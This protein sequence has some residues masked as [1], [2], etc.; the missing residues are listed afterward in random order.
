MSTQVPVAVEKNDPPRTS[1]MRGGSDT[2]NDGTLSS[3]NPTIAIGSSTSGVLPSWYSTEAFENMM[4]KYERIYSRFP[5]RLQARNA[6]LER[7]LEEYEEIHESAEDDM[8][9]YRE[10]LKLLEAEIRELRGE[11]RALTEQNRRLRRKLERKEVIEAEGVQRVERIE[12]PASTSKGK[13]K[14]VAKATEKED[15]E[16]VLE[17]R[18]FY[19][20]PSTSTIVLPGLPARILRF[21]RRVDL[22]GIHDYLDHQYK[23]KNEC[24]EA[25]TIVRK[26]MDANV[27]LGIQ[28]P[29]NLRDQAV[30]ISLPE[31]HDDVEVHTGAKIAA[32][33]TV[34][35]SDGYIEIVPWKY[36]EKKMPLRQKTTTPK[37]D[38]NPHDQAQQTIDIPIPDLAS[39]LPPNI[40]TTLF[41]PSSPP[42]SICSCALC[43][44]EYD[45]N[46]LVRTHMKP[47]VSVR[48]GADDDDYDDYYDDDEY[49]DDGYYDEEG[50]YDSGDSD[51][52]E[53]V[54]HED[55]AQDP[56]DDGW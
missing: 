14:E 38:D 50:D 46:V 19:F 29:D 51:Y 17:K 35:D 33:R 48:G 3:S 11:V 28:L 10:V 8:E 41:P 25:A 47:L 53:E 44:A 24:D 26:I 2:N 32:W 42:G 56:Y 18:F 23:I 1:M 7:Q 12:E 40:S 54:T 55:E 45:P 49:Y 37:V 52:D 31:D 4:Q 34:E 13:G 5:G 6:H 20:Y 16:E 27:S 21:P 9:W 30:V 39:F 43:A 15:E 36:E 22:P